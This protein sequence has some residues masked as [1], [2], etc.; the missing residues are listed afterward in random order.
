MSKLAHFV[1]IVSLT[2]HKL[3]YN[4][5]RLLLHTDANELDNIGMVV[6]LEDASFLQEFAFLFIGQGHAA[7]FDSDIKLCGFQFSLVDVTEVAL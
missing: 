5:N 2:R 3:H 4:H 7:G 1:H 6:L